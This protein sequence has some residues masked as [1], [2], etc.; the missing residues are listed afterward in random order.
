ML[1]WQDTLVNFRNK[2]LKR[3][4]PKLAA[5]FDRF[6]VWAVI[7]EPDKKFFPESVRRA[8]GRVQTCF[9]GFF[10]C[11]SSVLCCCKKRNNKAKKQSQRAE[12]NYSIDINTLSGTNDREGGSRHNDEGDIELLTRLEE[13]THVLKTV[14]THQV[15]LGGE[16]SRLNMRLDRLERMGQTVVQTGTRT[17]RGEYFGQPSYQDSQNFPPTLLKSILKKTPVEI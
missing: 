7:Y 12:N 17:N 6:I 3:R 8:C 10:N 4:F 15:K 5:R 11:L 13:L 2:F 1:D 16:M 9:A 14:H